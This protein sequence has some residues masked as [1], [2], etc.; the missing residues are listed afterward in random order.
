[1][2]RPPFAPGTRT[3]FLGDR[4]VRLD[5]VRL[6]WDLDLIGKRLSGVATLTVTVRQ[7]RLAVVTLDAIE[8]DV[9]GVTVGAL[10]PPFDNDGEMLRV[11][12]PE[13]QPEGSTIEIAVRYS[14]QPRRGLY[15]IGADADHP[16]RAP[17][18]WTQGQD[19]DSRHFW[20]C[21]DPPIEKFSTE[22]VC[23]A[24]AGSFVL[25]NG[26]L[27]ERIDLPGARV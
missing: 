18:C 10:P 20:P 25:S 23:T 19:D 11:T 16:E 12:L 7:D 4:P 6:D 26:D 2:P 17:Q 27:A 1:M 21:L 3:N 22:V 13:P 9:E 24:P 5:H 8:L 15:F 14:C